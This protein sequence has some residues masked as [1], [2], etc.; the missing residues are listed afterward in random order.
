V[1]SRPGRIGCEA[2]HLIAKAGDFALDTLAEKWEDVEAIT[3]CLVPF[4]NFKTGMPG[5]E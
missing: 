2:N 4:G 3:S 1:R 5:A